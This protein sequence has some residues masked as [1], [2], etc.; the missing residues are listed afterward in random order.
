M[1]YR[2]SWRACI[3]LLV[4]ALCQGNHYLNQF[5]IQ[6]E[7]G[8]NTAESIAREHG[9][10]VERE[11]PNIDVFILSH[12]HVHHRSKRSAQNI[13][14]K[15]L[16]HPQVLH[17][18]QEIELIREKRGI[19][20]DKQL[21]L[22]IREIHD[23]TVYHRIESPRLQLKDVIPGSSMQPRDPKFHDQWYIKNVG[24]SGGVKDIDLNV[25]VA[26]ENGYTGTGVVVSILDDGVDHTHTDLKD[27]YDPKA[28]TDLN[29][30]N[31]DP[32]PNVT[33]IYNSHGTRCAG[34]VAAA[35][36]ND[37]C[38]V[39]IAYTS[40]IGGVRILDGK[41]TDS[42]EAEALT[43]NM[44]YIDIYSA[45]WGPKDNGATMEGPKFYG[46]AAL[47]KGVTQG[48]KGL[49]NIYV[50]ATGNGGA[51][52]DDC[53]ADG[54]VSSIETLSVGSITDKGRRPY[55][56]ENCTSTIAVVPS[57]GEE[58]PGEERRH[59]ITK[60]KVVTTDI[61]NGC[62]ENFQGTS[63][64]APL[65]AGCVALLLQANPNL[66]WRD[67]QHIV[68]QT[69]RIPSIDDSWIINGAGLHVSHKFGYGVMDC[70]KMVQLAQTWNNVPEQHT[71]SY[72]KTNVN[73]KIGSRRHIESDIFVDGCKDDSSR[74]IDRLE[75][76]QIHVKLN[77][78][79]R[80]DIQIFLTSPA[81]TKSEML[82]P[83]SRDDFKGEFSF[84]FM[85][86]HTWGEFPSG[87]WKLE[88]YDNPG[89]SGRDTN[90]GWLSE[91][92]LILYG[93]SGK[94][95]DRMLSYLSREQRAITPDIDQ[96]T[97]IMDEEHVRS[98]RVS[99]KRNFTPS[100]V[101]NK[102]RKYS[103]ETDLIANELLKA[104]LGSSNTKRGNSIY[105]DTKSNHKKMNEIKNEEE[106]FDARSLSS[107]SQKEKKN[108]KSEKSDTQLLIDILT[109]LTET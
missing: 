16:D 20:Y 33:N 75:H 82:S 68:I 88:I 42:L 95:V 73:L 83:R 63:S 85:S 25:I 5:A 94:R 40:K 102:K 1:E 96:V 46:A 17:A 7:D 55:F 78:N 3:L 26:W 30:R 109:K 51:M 74:R 107:N 56:M 21:E 71:C 11:L 60:L 79:R 37:M 91:W 44:N 84:T 77:H 106:R 92:S 76:V 13:L 70:G 36:D 104:L 93:T 103:S 9:F 28:S 10:I 66:T 45:S 39:G 54:Y 49:G 67:V 64:A 24:Q 101:E 97:K 2:W 50:W 52:G 43:F 22:P 15:L 90:Q 27:N 14:Q 65:A 38:G 87:L 23:D 4:V 105:T 69:A 29:D 18:Q 86:V 62:I 81:G 35:A 80:G 99:I 72:N 57:G 19:I 12:P 108:L 47:R 8:R 61:N 59:N 31:S 6:C 32:M 98:K 34:E 58:V 48:R 53:S 89:N 41:V 100:K